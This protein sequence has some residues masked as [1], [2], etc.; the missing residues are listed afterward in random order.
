MA[1]SVGK[2]IGLVIALLLLGILL[3]IG[4]N[5]LTGFTSSDSNIQTIVAT[6]IPIVA[7]VSVLMWILPNRGMN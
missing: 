3:P 4:I 1:V 7:V 2:I 6:V 5:E